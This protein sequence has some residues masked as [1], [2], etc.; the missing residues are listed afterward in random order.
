M[1][2]EPHDVLIV[3]ELAAVTFIIGLFIG[4]IGA[5]GAGIAVAILTT[6]FGLPVHT[7]I[8]TAIAAMLFVTLSGAI[9]H[10]REGNIDHRLGVVIGLA[11]A[12]GAVLGADTSQTVSD[13][14]LGIAAGLALWGLAALVWIR[15]R[16]TTIVPG[17]AEI[18]FVSEQARSPR[19]WAAGIGLGATGGAA[20]AFFGVGMA[21]FLQLGLLTVHQLPLRQTVGTT[22]LTLV[23]ISA[24][25]GLAMARHGDVS[26]PHLIGLTIG[27]AS[28]AYIGARFTRRAPKQVLRGAIVAIP[29]LAGAMLLFL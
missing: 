18:P 6:V 15:T 21:P 9:S 17:Q 20:A 22:M 1:R 3:G 2:L 24:A 10:Y 28:G 16:I 25:G 19:E 5:G 23:F 8:G 14:T 12:A 7:A 26:V 4:F 29:F 13:R 11:G 27:L